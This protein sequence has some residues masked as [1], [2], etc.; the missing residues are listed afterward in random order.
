MTNGAFAAAQR[1]CFAALAGLVIC[2]ALAGAEPLPIRLNTVGYL[3]NGDKQASI[4]AACTNFAVLRAADGS[5][6]F[7]GKVS[8]PVVSKD[9][10]EQ[11]Y[12]ADF[13]ALNQPGEYQLDV[14]G[15]GRSAP[16]RVAADV[17][18][19][20]YYI[21]MRGFYLWRCG[22]AVSATYRGKTFAHGS[23]HTNDAWLDFVGGG[24]ARK[25]GSKGWHDAGDYNKYV[26]N[27][28]VTMGTLLRAWEDFG[29]RLRAIRLDLPES[30]RNLPDFLVELK[31]ELEWLLTMQAPDGS[32]YH[33]LS[34]RSFGPFLLP[35]L[36]TAERF[37]TPWGSEAT[38]DFVGLTAQAARVFQPYDAAF[39]QQCLQAAQRSYQFLRDHPE[40]HKANQEGFKTG[41]Y[42]I[43]SP[44]RR[45]NQRPNNRLWAE[46]ELFET[47]GAA[48]VLA[49][50]EARIKSIH[51]RVNADF[52]WEEVKELGL[53]TYA[54]SHRSGRD[55][56]LVKLVR[57]NLLAVADQ[58]VQTRDQNAYHRPLGSLHYWGCNGGVARQT[59]LLV[60]AE[61][62][63]GSEAGPGALQKPSRGR[64]YREVCLDAL[65]H[66]FGRNYYGRS[67][68]TG[69]GFA[70]P[71]HP[72]DR[73]C[74][75]GSQG[76]PWPGYLVGGP[77]PKASDW[78]DIQGD[79]KT[80]EIAINW[81]SA[82]VYALAACL[83][84]PG[85]TAQLPN[86]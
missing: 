11:L 6:A 80:N 45:L 12:T 8:G 27:A 26:V 73:R 63:M 41:E 50:L 72:H 62:V 5:T 13:S 9:T 15:V 35:E 32:V 55:P 47:T 51:A 66:L 64:V 28:G 53:I 4:A 48:D 10:G 34:T 56:E 46:A 78:Q 65:N 25:D 70:P 33:K 16:F 20:P 49:S 42:E 31:W 18:R 60:A 83:P 71:K 68:V 75:D 57:N 58:I 2:R 44:D 1:G 61:R 54:L 40:Y 86:Q 43:N 30:G 69:L 84:G 85:L 74:G 67:F 23:C 59:V 3:P 7:A 79:F 76:E 37:F 29:P 81:N 17:Y 77:H 22:M 21:V 39:A 24:H 36:E 82:L 38:A 14:P 52:D 19:E